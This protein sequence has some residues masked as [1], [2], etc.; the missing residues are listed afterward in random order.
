MFGLKHEERQFFQ[1]CLD[2]LSRN[3]L[4]HSM[5]EYMQHGSTSCLWH[6]IAVAYYS[7]WFVHAF[8]IKCNHKNLV[9]GALLHD[10]FLYDWHVPSEINKA[11]G[12]RHPRIALENAKRDCLLNEVECNI[13]ECHMFPLTPKPPRFRESLVV[14]LIDKIC[15]LAE[16]FR[17][18]PYQMLKRDFY[19][20]IPVSSKGELLHDGL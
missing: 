3:T 4:F 6:S 7:L 9:Y 2:D 17:R 10:Y 20:T 12:F 5:D 13:I 18:R 15:S 1:D 11:H 14:C 8:R 19:A 16:V